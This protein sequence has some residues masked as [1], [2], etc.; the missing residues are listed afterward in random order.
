MVFEGKLF[1]VG[2][3]GP[4]PPISPRDTMDVLLDLSL[5]FE[6]C[7]NI[8]I[9]SSQFYK[10]NSNCNEIKKSNKSWRGIV[11]SLHCKFV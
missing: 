6:L 9:N 10:F 8:N 11:S 3:S 2:V 5:G 7:I 4:P 1:I